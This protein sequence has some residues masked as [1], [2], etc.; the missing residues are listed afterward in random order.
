MTAGAASTFSILRGGY[1]AFSLPALTPLAIHFFL[2]GDMLHY[3][4]GG[5]FVLFGVLLWRLSV[6]TYRIHRSSFLLRFEN[7]EMIEHLQ[8]AMETWREV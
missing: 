2:I 5:M 7:R 6:H 8:E 4:M 3:A 1:L